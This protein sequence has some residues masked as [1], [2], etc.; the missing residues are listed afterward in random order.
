MSNSKNDLIKKTAVTADRPSK[1]VYVAAAI[2]AL[3][4]MLFGYDT[5]VISGA[6]L[7]IRKDFLLSPA[8]VEVVVS[9]VLV[10]ALLGA[11]VGGVLADRFGRRRVIIVTAILF[12]AG[13]I[14]TALAPSISLLIAGRIIVGTAIGVA[15]FT[16]PLYISEVAPVNIRG[17]LVSINQVALTSGIVI[18]YLVDYSLV[19][20]QGWRWMFALATV[21]A[22]ILAIGMFLLPESPRWLVSRNLIDSAQKVLIRIRGNKDVN[23]ELEDIQKSLAVQSGGWR[24]L[25]TPLI[26]P[27]LIVGVGLAILQQITGINTVI[28]YAP[29][30]FEFTGIKSASASILATVGVGLVN[31]VMTVVALVLVDRI[32]RRPLL[33]AGLSGMI[34]GLGVLGLAFFLPGLSG[35]LGWIA[36]ISLMLY[37]GAFAVGLGPVF[38]LLIS[39]IYPLKIRGVAMSIATSANWGANLF[40]ALTFLTL[41][42]ATGRS[43]TFWIYALVGVAAWLFTWFLVPETKGR[44]LEE[45]EAH[46]Q[47]GKHPRTMGQQK[48]NK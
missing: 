11:I 48:P 22:I 1:F 34:V 38:W 33:L 2:S 26:R 41:I 29:M 4:G 9:C 46:W 20:V 36:E 32:G 16:T 40:V 37:V 44:S 17:R 27:A 24:D 15:S 5:G 47:A 45:I 43:L 39:E 10:G 19:A 25:F 3:G 23:V 35:S 21:P 6:I 42:Q 7:F 28:Y 18:S 14:E 30:I 13:A 12:A 31:V 8:Q